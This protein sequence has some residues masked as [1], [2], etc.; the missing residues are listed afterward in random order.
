MDKSRDLGGQ[1]LPELLDHV[2]YEI[3]MMNYT[4]QELLQ[5]AQSGPAQ[6]VLLES[7]LIHIRALDEFF[8]KNRGRSTDLIERDFVKDGQQREPHFQRDKINVEVAH[9]TSKRKTVRTAREW[10]PADTARP[11][12]DLA[13]SFLEQIFSD[14][15]LM[16]HL[17]NGERTRKLIEDLRRI[18]T[19]IGK[20]D[21]GLSTL[22]V[23]SSSLTSDTTALG[24]PAIDSLSQFRSPTVAGPSSG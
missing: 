5:Q 13:L 22:E 12:V 8:Q 1:S 7:F 15:G 4:L 9:I 19:S 18:E 2:L 17:N 3:E 20:K 10:K 11:I 6:T 21:S 16:E 23:G 14:A 24:S